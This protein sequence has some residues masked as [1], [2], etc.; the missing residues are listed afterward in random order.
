MQ[1]ILIEEGWI[2]LGEGR[3]KSLAAGPRDGTFVLLLH[4]G[5]FT[6]ET[7]RDLGT[8]EVLARAGLRCV[9]IDLPGYGKSPATEFERED[10]LAR[11]VGQLGTR[12]VIVVSPSMSGGYSL[13][14]VLDHAHLVLGYVP[15]SPAQLKRYSDRLGEIQ[16]P[17]R[18]LWG[19][20]DTVFPLEDGRAMQAAISGAQL[21]VFEGASH[22]CYLDQP[23]RFH[24]ELTEFAAQLGDSRK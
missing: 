21:S 1:D 3:L 6:S 15:I 17:T 11:L 4:G 9:A 2:D 7:W 5:R 16:V 22:P 23:E 8:L 18:I 14:F 24:L 10:V 20:A 19:S 12:S 13:P